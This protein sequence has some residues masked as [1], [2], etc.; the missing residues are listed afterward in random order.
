MTIEPKFT[1]RAQDALSIEV[2]AHY[3][4]AAQRYSLIAHS[5]EVRTAIA[6]FIVWQNENPEKVKMPYHKHIPLM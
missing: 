6:E 4:A 1:I 2:L 5:H 3:L